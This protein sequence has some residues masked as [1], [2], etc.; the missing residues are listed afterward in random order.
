MLARRTRKAATPRWSR[1]PG[2]TGLA[3]G[4]G[5]GSP[6]PGAGP[7]PAVNTAPHGTGW[8]GPGRYG[9]R[10]RTKGVILGLRGLSVGRDFSREEGRGAGPVEG[11]PRD[12]PPF[13]RWWRRQLRCEVR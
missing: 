13:V 2:S 12:G 9:G 4:R 8:G 10:R 6:R 1:A 11:R 7:L 5:R 3:A